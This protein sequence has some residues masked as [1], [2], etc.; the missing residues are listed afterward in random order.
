MAFRHKSSSSVEFLEERAAKTNI[1]I[2][3]VIAFLINNMFT[4]IHE[5][6]FTNLSLQLIRTRF[7]FFLNKNFT[8]NLVTL[9][10]L[11]LIVILA[12][13]V[14]LLAMAVSR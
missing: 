6:S 2:N 3:E 1:F 14:V 10:W 4:F 13:L 7:F 11:G 9:L 12:I 5:S 8:I